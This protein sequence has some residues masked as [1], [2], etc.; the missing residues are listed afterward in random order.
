MLPFSCGRHGNY[1]HPPCWSGLSH[2]LPAAPQPALST[3]PGP[4]AEPCWAAEWDLGPRSWVGMQ[5]LGVRGHH[6]KG[7]RAQSEQCRQRAL[8]PVTFPV[9]HYWDGFSPSDCELLSSC[10]AEV[11]LHFLG[12]M[13]H[14]LHQSLHLG[15]EGWPHQQRCPHVPPYQSRAGSQVLVAAGGSVAALPLLS[16]GSGVGL[17]PLP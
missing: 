8:L 14:R 16:H 15:R 13:Q 4:H 17:Q 3:A 10:L 7:C 9:P 2:R 6:P 5:H 1:F 11:H 12:Y